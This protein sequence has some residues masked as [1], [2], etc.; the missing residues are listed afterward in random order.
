MGFVTNFSFQL[1]R[2][3]IG[4]IH[5]AW[6]HGKKYLLSFLTESLFNLIYEVQEFDRV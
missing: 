4:L 3:G 1:C 2:I 6:L 5:I